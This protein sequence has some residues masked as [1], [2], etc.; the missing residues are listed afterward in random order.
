[1]S[2]ILLNIK[3][4][5]KRAMRTVPLTQTDHYPGELER[6]G[7]GTKCKS[8]KQNPRSEFHVAIKKQIITI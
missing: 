3:G 4:T 6:N 2:D 7:I 5:I 8:V 1:M